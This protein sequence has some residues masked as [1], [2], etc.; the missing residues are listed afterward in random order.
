M[1]K[2]EFATEIDAAA[3]AAK[4]WPFYDE[5]PDNPKDW[6][7]DWPVHML[8]CGDVRALQYVLDF[9]E[10][11]LP[12]GDRNSLLANAVQTRRVSMS[13]LF[14]NDDGTPIPG[15]KEKWLSPP[16]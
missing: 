14:L 13:F 8:D 11:Q 9:V 5:L 15:A 3:E 7:R 12:P 1:N 4:R 6:P 2:F 10:A 16:R